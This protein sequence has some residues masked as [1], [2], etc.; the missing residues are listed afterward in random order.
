[1]PRPSSPSVRRPVRPPLWLAA[2]A[3]ALLLS[4][5]GAVKTPGVIPRGAI[6]VNVGA[7]PVTGPLPPGFLGFSIEY[8]SSLGYS[9]RDPSHLNPLYL[10]L[11]RGLNPG[12]SPVLRFGGDTADWTWWP[13]PGM[14]KPRGIRY[15]LTRRWLAVTAATARAL[16]ARLILG[17]NFE[18]DSRRIA[19]AESRALLGAIGRPYVAGFELGNEPEAYSTL[20]WY[21][22]HRTVPVLGRRPGYGLN[23][24]LPDYASVRAALPTDV[25]LVGPAS[26]AP[27][28][29]AGLGRFLR[30]EP[31]IAVATFHRYPLHRCATARTSIA[32]PSIPNLLRPGASSGPATSLAAAVAVAH[33]HGV[34]FRADEL[35]SVSCGG[36]RGVSD[37]FAAAL[38]TLDTLFNMDRAHVDGVNIHTFQSAIY[39]PFAFTH[40]H[41][42]WLAQVRPMYYGLLL[43]ARA[44]P[45]GSRLLLTLHRGP[46]YLRI[47]TTRGP[48]GRERVLVVNDSLHRSLV[49]AVR[50]P[51]RSGSATVARLRAPSASSQRGVALAGQSFGNQTS[52][53]TLSGAA[54]TSSITPTRGHFVVWLPA[55][56]AVLLTTAGP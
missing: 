34:R 13:V 14:A 41:G 54:H 3:V 46:S 44:A 55:A 52:T 45:P 20:G 8:P 33:A 25:P 50:L 36:A 43:F 12:Q 18:A 19:S 51:A 22:L 10:Q 29:L 31:R 35:N 39:A 2:L 5:C 47:W 11:V 48:G 40:R 27:E 49:V 7:R 15:A 53:G 37:T 23:A 24:Y 6:M 56:S 28:W 4:A 21:Y 32:Y 26:G 1:M 17:I 9:G 42:R 38:W 16:D 30:A